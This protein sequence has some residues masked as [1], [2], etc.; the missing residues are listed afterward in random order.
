[1]HVLA[2]EEELAAQIE[3]HFELLGCTGIE[4]RLQDECPDVIADLLAVRTSAYPSLLSVQI[5]PRCE[6]MRTAKV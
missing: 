6:E 4:D 2:Q 5:A 1:M 3:C